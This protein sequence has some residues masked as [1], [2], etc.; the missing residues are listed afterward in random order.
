MHSV[1][2]YN[3]ENSSINTVYTVYIAYSSS[4]RA[5]RPP[6]KAVRSRAAIFPEKIAGA[7]IRAGEGVRKMKN[8]KVMERVRGRGFARGLRPA[9]QPVSVDGSTGSPLR[10]TEKC[11]CGPSD[12][13]S[14]A[15]VPTVPMTSPAATLSPGETSVSSSR[16]A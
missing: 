5:P 13:S 8:E 9:R 16:L 3:W 6:V 12:S 14:F 1:S 7:E 15:V 10:V 2:A 4:C 11:R